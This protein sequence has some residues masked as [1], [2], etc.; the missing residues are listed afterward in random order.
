MYRWL[1]PGKSTGLRIRRPNVSLNSILVSHL[2]LLQD[3]LF[4]IRY[5][6]Y[7]EYKRKWLNIMKVIKHQINQNPTASH[8]QFGH[9]S[10]VSYHHLSPGLLQWIPNMPPSFCPWLL[11]YTVAWVILLNLSQIISL[12]CTFADSQLWCL[13]YL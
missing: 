2:V 13:I 6:T 11:L 4:I 8:Q 7:L 12:Y 3:S 1:Q 5:K 9:H 10:S